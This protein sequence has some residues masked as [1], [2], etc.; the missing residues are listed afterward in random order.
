M[1]DVITVKPLEQFGILCSSELEQEYIDD[2]LGEE[3]TKFV[4]DEFDKT[5]GNWRVNHLINI[6]YMS[7]NIWDM[8]FDETMVKKLEHYLNDKFRIKYR[9]K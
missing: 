6:G 4:Q 7:I 1:I 3:L 2:C 8:T 9:F 5:N